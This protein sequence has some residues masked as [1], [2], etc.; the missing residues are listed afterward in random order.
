MKACIIASTRESA[1]KTSL[2]IGMA[3]AMGKKC[4]Y[5]K[6]F[7]DRLVYQR[8][9]S[10][11]YDAALMMR[12]WELDLDPDQ[13]TLGFS[14]SK[15]RF[16][17][18]ER[19]LSKTL[20]E[21]AA[22]ASR[23]TDFLFIEGGKNISYGASISLDPLTISRRTGADVIIIASGEADEVLDD[24]AFFKSFY[25][26]PDIK[27]RGVIINKVRDI[28]D[29]SETALKT[30]TSSGMDVLGV[31][32]YD[33]GLTCYSVRYLAESIFAKVI[34]GEKGLGNIVKNIFVGAM[35]AEESMRNP[36]FARG[37]NVIITS[38]DRSDMILASLKKGT[39]AVVLTNNIIPDQNIIARA[40]EVNIPLL[41]VAPDTFQVA[42]QI[43]RLEALITP[44]DAEKIGIL[45]SLAEKHITF[46]G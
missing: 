4:A 29:F 35:S 19:S 12:L 39:S 14:H 1:G 9:K 21:M 8:K 44:D 3:S 25:N 37:D 34:G 20:P 6:P 32:P 13:I 40:A 31:V 24:I 10:W 11:D 36:L 22:D 16:V 18:D 43:D 23:G 26:A 2:I 5:L 28:E 45:A 30:I 33:E 7:G 41:L 17:H 42:K 27:I 38:G 15:L 46:R